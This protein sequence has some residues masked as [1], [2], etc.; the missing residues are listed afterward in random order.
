MRTRPVNNQKRHLH[1]GAFTL[2][3]V[4]I[5]SALFVISS[6]AGY[7]ALAQNFQIIQAMRENLRATQILQD[8]TEIVRLYTWQQLTNG[9]F[10]PK[11]FTNYFNP[12]GRAGETQGAS[13]YGTVTIGNA[14]MT[15][16][17]AGDLKLVTFRLSWTNSNVPHQREIS[18]LVSHY[19]LH[20]YIYNTK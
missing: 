3:E 14:P 11:Y 2:V 5:A 18:T 12:S 13:Y 9:A 8:K 15:E 7:L 1:S 16:S 10:V 4:V 19:G 17:Y 6:V 20:N